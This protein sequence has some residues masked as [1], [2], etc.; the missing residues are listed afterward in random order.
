LHFSGVLVEF[1]LEIRLGSASVHYNKAPGKLR[2]KS[3]IMTLAAFVAGASSLLLA[4]TWSLLKLPRSKLIL[5]VTYAVEDK[6]T[7][8][9]KVHGGLAAED[10]EHVGR[11]AL[12]E[13]DQEVLHLY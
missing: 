11:H 2:F 9:H 10:G 13:V 12:P 1:H 3:T 8:H 5:T 4:W 6:V 7:D